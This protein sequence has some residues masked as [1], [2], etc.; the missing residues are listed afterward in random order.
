MRDLS[1]ASLDLF[2]DADDVT[3]TMPDAYPPRL[4]KREPVVRIVEYSRY[5]RVARSERRQVGFTRNQS[6]S[7][8]C[9]VASEPEAEGTLLR[10]ALRTVD[11]GGTLD[12][13]A[14]V[15]WCERREDGRYWIGLALLERAGRRMLKVRHSDAT[16]SARSGT[17]TD[18]FAESA[19]ARRLSGRA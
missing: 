5:P 12:A 8:M 19:E 17:D 18:R 14:H 4:E 1:R 13:L 9:I 10:V 15:A 16:G 11:G 3:E 2:D 6:R 7:G